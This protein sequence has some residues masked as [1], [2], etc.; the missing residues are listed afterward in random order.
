LNA[1][2]LFLN[3]TYFRIHRRN[4]DRTGNEETPASELINNTYG[5]KVNTHDVESKPLQTPTTKLLMSKKEDVG[6]RLKC[7]NYDESVMIYETTQYALHP[8]FGQD[9]LS[10]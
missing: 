6:R 1:L 4:V 2:I 9:G 8:D 7:K 5:D 10:I 3:Q